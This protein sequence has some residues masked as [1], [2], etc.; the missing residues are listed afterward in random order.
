MNATPRWL[1][2]DEQRAWMAYV[3]FST[4]LG[5]YLNRQLR[6]DAGTTHADYTLLAQLSSAPDQALGMSELA[7]R[8]KITRSRLTHAVNRLAEAASWTAV[9][10]P[11]TGAASSPSSPTRA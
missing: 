9:R 2:A 11:R 1:D 4:L 6:R 8:L 5:D 3:E 7:R 10:T